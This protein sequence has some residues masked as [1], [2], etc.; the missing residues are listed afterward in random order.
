MRRKYASGTSVGV[1]K[2]RGDIDNLLRQWGCSQIQWS[3]DYKG[4]RVQLRFVWD[5]KDMDYM[6]RFELQLPTD[7]ELEKESLHATLGSICEGKLE[8]LQRDRGKQ[9]H[10]LLLLWLKASLNA[11]EAGIVAAEA[12]FLPFLEGKDGATV[13]EVAL[14]RLSKLLSGSA[15]Q[16]LPGSAKEKGDGE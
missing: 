11:V 16:L 3:D 9:E 14:P 12:L 13:A 6:A 15:K 8:R 5:H 4:G 7:A 2:S 10:R 1:A